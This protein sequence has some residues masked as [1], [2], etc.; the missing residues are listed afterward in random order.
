M[1]N[2]MTDRIAIL[3]TGGAGY[4]GSHICK[5]LYSSGYNPVTFDNLSTGH[6]HLVKWGKLE[7][8]DVLDK[9]HL[10]STIQK[11][12]IKAIIH[13]AAHIAVGESVA[14]PAKYYR[15]N[16]MGSLAVL[17]AMIEC[18]LDKI[19]F[20]STAAVYGNP[21][22][23]PIDENSE[24][25]PI[26]PYG[27]SKL[28]VEQI[29]ADH[30]IS[31]NIK[32]VILRYFNVAGADLD[33]ETGCEHKSPNN[34]IPILMNV[35]IGKKDLVEIYGTDYET[36]DGT[37]IRDYIHVS[38]LAHAHILALEYLLKKNGNNVTLNLGTGEGHSVKE[39][40]ESTERAINRKLNI[41]NSPRRAG[42][43]SILYNSPAKAKQIINFE[44]KHK[45]LDIITKSAWDYQQKINQNDF[46]KL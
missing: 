1:N 27:H 12:G 17:E 8:G 42:D 2:K 30:F 21:K 15:N 10:I 7:E 31:N 18:G 32:S 35:A 37:A 25:N 38:D 33:S 3:V 34:L 19:V 36:P 11:Y 41:K 16:V 29:L 40:I 13:M 22:Y 14:N 28:M 20:S 4:I 26:N 23:L 24:T 9:N 45:D 39:V 43:A 44:A 5:E 46:K 6:K